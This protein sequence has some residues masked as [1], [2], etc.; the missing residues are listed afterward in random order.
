MR[1]VAEI[2]SIAESGDLVAAHE[3]LDALLEMGPRN[4]EALK[5]RAKLFEVAGRFQQEAKIWDQIARIDREDLDLTD[6]IARRQ[7]EDRENFYFTDALPGGGKRFIAFPRRMVRAASFGL[8]GCVL[9]LALARMSSVWPVLNHPAIMLSSFGLFVI[10]PW[11]GILASYARSLRYIAVTKDGL[12]VATRFKT[13][14]LPWSDVEKVVLAQD[15]R[16][17]TYQLS[18]IVLGKG[19]GQVSLELDFNENTTPIRARSYFIREIMQTW[20]EPTYASRRTIDTGKKS[21][22]KA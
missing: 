18:L 13:H 21:T 11:F 20:G 1:N 8:F 3:A 16:H 19:D 14:R 12:E 7:H 9:F 2:Q 10:S 22:I 4:V 6:Y 15:D 5:L 17:D